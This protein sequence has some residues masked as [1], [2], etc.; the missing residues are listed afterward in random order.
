M[1]PEFKLKEIVVN[2]P[3]DNDVKLGSNS[4]QIIAEVLHVGEEQKY[5]KVGDKI[6]YS[7][8]IPTKD[9]EQFGRIIAGEGLIIC[10]IVE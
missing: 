4:G 5:Y 3:N 10:K 7:K 1:K 6:M 8:S 2:I 9:I